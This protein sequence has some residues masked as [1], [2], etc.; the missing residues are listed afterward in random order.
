MNGCRNKCVVIRRLRRVR[1]ELQAKQVV[2]SSAL[3]SLNLMNAT[4][5]TRNGKCTC[6]AIERLRQHAASAYLRFRSLAVRLHTTYCC[7]AEN[8]RSHRPMHR[9]HAA[10]ACHA[11]LCGFGRVSRTSGAVS[12]DHRD[13]HC[14][15]LSNSA[16]S[17]E[18][19]ETHDHGWGDF[20][21][22]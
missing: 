14:K 2:T 4:G 17:T 8:R 5:R 18:I 10:R 22:L 13:Q 3:R 15:R 1:A 9:R 11:G 7:L 12:R 6:D 21:T 20:L 16:G 19:L